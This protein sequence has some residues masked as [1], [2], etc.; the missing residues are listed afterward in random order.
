MR[1]ARR[2]LALGIFLA[3]LIGAWRFAS[4]NSE[5]VR[6][7]FWLGEITEVE[8]WVVLAMAFLAGAL[9]T[10]LLVS[11]RLARAGLLARRYRVAV[12]GLEA[13]LHQ[14]RNLPLAAEDEAQAGDSLRASSWDVGPSA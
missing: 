1:V 7:Y 12:T 9:S 10:G 6:V 5:P 8:L 3:V 2:L 14:L 4:E 11:Y 13:E